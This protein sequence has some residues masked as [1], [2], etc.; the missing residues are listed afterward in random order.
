M[1][2]NIGGDNLYSTFI[3]PTNNNKLVPP[4]VPAS[5]KTVAKDNINP[6]EFL[7]AGNTL[8]TANAGLL[9]KPEKVKDN[10]GDVGAVQKEVTKKEG[11]IVSPLNTKGEV[12]FVPVV[13]EQQ[14]K[15][16]QGLI[17]AMNGGPRDSFLPTILE[18]V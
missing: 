5:S 14:P 15:V 12:F 9:S 7:S 11:G 17:E 18:N 13:F 6:D 16:K 8:V 2:N 4:P 3:N 10:W 1:I